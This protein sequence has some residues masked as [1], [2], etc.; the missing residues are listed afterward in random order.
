MYPKHTFR[1]R[2][3]SFYLVLAYVEITKAAISRCTQISC[4]AWWEIQTIG[5]VN[6]CQY[7]PNKNRGRK[8]KREV[9]LKMA[10][11]ITAGGESSWSHVDCKPN[12]T[13]SLT[14]ISLFFQTYSLCP[15]KQ[16]AM[17]SDFLIKGNY[18]STSHGE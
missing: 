5:F 15:R 11:E 6:Q 1:P 12:K 9:N 14:D 3:S 10:E 7:P 13:P 17:F 4:T 8:V 2:R 18:E 16:L